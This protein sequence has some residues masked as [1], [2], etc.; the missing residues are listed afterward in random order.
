MMHKEKHTRAT[1]GEQPSKKPS[2]QPASG[3]GELRQ[4]QLDDVVG[5]ADEIVIT[6]QVDKASPKLF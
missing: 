5:G 1:S 2:A 3:A 4:E 6:K